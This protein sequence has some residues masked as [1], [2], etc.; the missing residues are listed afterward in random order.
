MTAEQ[1]PLCRI[2]RKRG[3]ISEFELG[4]SFGR[5]VVRLVWILALVGLLAGGVIASD[6]A[7][8]GR[9]SPM[10]SFEPCES[11]HMGLGKYP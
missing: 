3:R 6:A 1:L 2:T 9:A 10:G 11:S 5:M 4:P 7:P 8:H